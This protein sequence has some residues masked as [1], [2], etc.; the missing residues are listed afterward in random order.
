MKKL[1]IGIIGC[2]AIFRLMHL[3]VLKK[4]KNMFNISYVY[5]INK[6][7]IENSGVK[8]AFIAEEWKSI[9]KNPEINAVFILTPISTHVKYTIYALSNNKHVFL[10]K[11][12]ALIIKEIDLMIKVSNKYRRYVQVGMVLRHSNWF[13]KL[14]KI[15][16]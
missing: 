9:L 14:K 2:G 5:D 10:E 16:D 1:N 6:A 13:L 8:N 15:I 11:P 3:Q 7:A 12:A 4:L